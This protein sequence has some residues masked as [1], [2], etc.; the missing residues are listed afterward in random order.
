[1]ALGAAAV[2]GAVLY[3]RHPVQ[4]DPSPAAAGEPGEK[5]LSRREGL[6]RPLLILLA[7]GS[8]ATFLT[9]ELRALAPFAVP[10]PVAEAGVLVTWTLAALPLLALARGDR[11]RLLLVAVSLLL[12]TLALRTMADAEDWRAV[13]PPLR[14]AILNVRFLAGL[15]MVVAAGLYA[16]VVPEFPHLAA[17]TGARLGALGGGVAAVLLLWNLSAEVLLWPL[18]GRPAPHADKVRSAGLSILWALYAFAAMGV[19][20]WRRSPGLRL[21]AIALFGLAVAKVLVVDLSALDAIYRILSFLVLGAVLLVASFLYAR[22]R[23]D[24]RDLP[25]PP[26]PLP[27]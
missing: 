5:V 2:I 21:G 23:R 13:A 25:P 10:G 26:N 19:G 27:G 16:R 14:P 12:A 4:G 15:L 8:L 6:V 22:Y 18:P 20:M 1:V 7:V 3:G 11:T 17:R 9:M 24:V